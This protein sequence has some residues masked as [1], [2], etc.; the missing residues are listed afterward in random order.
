MYLS[1]VVKRSCVSAKGLESDM[2][3][4]VVCGCGADG[5]EVEAGED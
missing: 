1:P 4:I 2:D 3:G 5:R